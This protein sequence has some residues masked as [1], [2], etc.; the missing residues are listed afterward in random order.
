[1]PL[2]RV[3][4]KKADRKSDD[5]KVNQPNSTSQAEKQQEPKQANKRPSLQQRTQ[6]GNRSDTTIDSE[7]YTESRKNSAQMKSAATSGDEADA[8]YKE[9]A[10]KATDK[11]HISEGR[12]SA[13]GEHLT[14]G[15]H[16][17][18]NSN[19]NPVNSNEDEHHHHSH[20]SSNSLKDKNKKVSSLLNYNNINDLGNEKEYSI[21][22][23]KEHVSENTS[24]EVNSSTEA[25][26]SLNISHLDIADKTR[27]ASISSSLN[28]MS[29]INLNIKVS[30][31]SHS[32][33]SQSLE[34]V[35]KVT[36]YP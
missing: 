21:N 35:S 7:K 3:P 10:V 12:A 9:L 36:V 16:V 5:G 1:M 14:Q 24:T 25:N 2:V 22:K 20:H 23:M 18:Q 13:E 31:N 28:S 17:T 27:T 8:L 32:K 30:N 6:A 33:D 19:K 11:E 15:L 29:N 34:N 4:P 26:Y